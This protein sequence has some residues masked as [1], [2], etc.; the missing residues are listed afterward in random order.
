MDR[1]INKV[2]EVWFE[3]KHKENPQRLT[4]RK[5]KDGKTYYMVDRK[6]IS[7]FMDMIGAVVPKITSL[8]CRILENCIFFD[9]ED[10]NRV[11]LCQ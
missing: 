3:D 9:E 1:V 10:L 6:N 2:F 8:R 7:E 5:C 11:I 4:I